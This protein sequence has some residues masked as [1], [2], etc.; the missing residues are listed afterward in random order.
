MEWRLE[1]NEARFV[2]ISGLAAGLAPSRAPPED[3]ILR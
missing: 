1:M 3:R 2:T